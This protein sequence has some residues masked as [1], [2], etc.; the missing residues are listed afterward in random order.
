MEFNGMNG[1]KVLDT[2]DVTVGW[3]NTPDYGYGRMRKPVTVHV[4]MERLKRREMYETVDHAYVAEPLDFAITTAVWRPNRTD[5]I[6]GG[7]TVEPAARADKLR[8]RVECREGRQTPRSVAIPPE[9]VLA[10]VRASDGRLRARQ[11][12]P[13][14]AESRPDSALPGHRVQIRAFLAG[15]ATAGRI[16][17]GHQGSFRTVTPDTW[18]SRPEKG[19]VGKYQSIKGENRNDRKPQQAN[20]NV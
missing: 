10:R 7:A 3:I 14:H 20:E 18:L 11:L 6:S 17:A 19:V 13:E 15:P 12:R 5:M 4:R 9:R 16:R 8:R 2:G 1:D